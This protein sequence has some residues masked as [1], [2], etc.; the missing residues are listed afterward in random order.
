MLHFHSERE[1]QA[2]EFMQYI[3]RKFLI[4]VEIIARTIALIP[5]LYYL[6]QVC[7]VLY[8]NRI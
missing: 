8:V 2:E 4:M 5:R 3:V 7:N 1:Y 6:W